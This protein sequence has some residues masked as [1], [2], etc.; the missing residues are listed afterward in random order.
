MSNYGTSSY[1]YLDKPIN[2]NTYIVP[3]YDSS[4]Y[5]IPNYDDI[6][7]SHFK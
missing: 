5:K 2:I 7:T 1:D 6:K 3:T 4:N